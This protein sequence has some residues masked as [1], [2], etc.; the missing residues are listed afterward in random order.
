MVPS[1]TELASAGAGRACR[2]PAQSNSGLGPAVV[3]FF[4]NVNDAP[5]AAAMN[6]PAA[7]NS[8]RT[9]TA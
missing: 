6:T 3:S 9:D 2:D 8:A 7:T 4:W 1:G 5:G